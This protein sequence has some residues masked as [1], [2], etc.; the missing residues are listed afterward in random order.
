MP[1]VKTIVTFRSKHSELR[2]LRKSAEQMMNPTYGTVSVTA[3]EVVYEFHAGVLEV[4][5]GQDILEDRFDAD[6]QSWESQDALGYL[7]GH[8][9]FN[10]RF[11]EVEE[12]APDPSLMYAA[13]TDAMIA[14]NLEM[15]QAL[16]DEEFATWNRPE[17]LDRIRSGMDTLEAHA[18]AEPA[19]PPKAKE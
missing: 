5:P 19:K 1:A 14:G 10:V 3:P 18:V 9:D 17:I 7:R 2:I 4:R 8:P 6:T 16:G 11:V 15:L 12:V 13:I